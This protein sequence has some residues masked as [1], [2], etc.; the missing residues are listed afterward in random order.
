MFL[1]LKA[2]FGQLELKPDCDE[3]AP[4]KD[5]NCTTVLVTLQH[6]GV[7][8]MHS[9]NAYSTPLECIVLTILL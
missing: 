4:T 9:T 8:N 7:V 6:Q 3:W 1:V 5:A 2:D